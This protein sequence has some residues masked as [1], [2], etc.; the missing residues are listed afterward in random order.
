VAEAT[1]TEGWGFAMLDLAIA[2]IGCAAG[3]AGLVFVLD[4]TQRLNLR[5]DP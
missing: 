5:T 3:V 1:L 4:T 2:L